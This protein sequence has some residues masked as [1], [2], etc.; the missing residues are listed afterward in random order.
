MVAGTFR[1]VGFVAGFVTFAGMALGQSEEHPFGAPEPLPDRPADIGPIEPVE[2]MDRDNYRLQRS[3]IDRERLDS[4]SIDYDR[5]QRSNSRSFRSP[6][7][8]ID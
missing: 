4:S 7:G 1:C 2:G 3:N 6:F 5:L 8:R